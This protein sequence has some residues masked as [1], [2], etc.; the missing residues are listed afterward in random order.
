MNV[1]STNELARAIGVSES[2]IKRWADEGA[3]RCARTAGGHRRIPLAE[4][5]RFVR[6]SRSPL[7]H[8]E[9][10][11]L[12]ALDAPAARAGDEAEMLCGYLVEGAEKQVRGLILGM[13]LRG[14]SVAAII[15]GPMRRAME[16]VGG[17]WHHEP[18]G[19]FFEHRATDLC[20]QALNGLR[21]LLPA[22]EEGPVALGG[23]TAGDPICCPRWPP[24]RRYTP[25]TSAPAI[26]APTCP[27]RASPK[28]LSGCGRPWCASPSA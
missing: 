16:R 24:P 10:L 21:A 7:A 20:I 3:I 12:P 8:P 27:S 4:A 15:D 1:L 26:S 13:Y 6:D 14:F 17:L 22:N 19:I 9:L 5:I 25:S 18:S 11:G 23:A 2:S 28:R